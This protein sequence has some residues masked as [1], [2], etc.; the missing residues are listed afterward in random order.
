MY[1]LQR[2]RNFQ[3]IFRVWNF[4]HRQKAITYFLYTHTH[5]LHIYILTVDSRRTLS[6]L[7][8]SRLI[9]AHRNPLVKYLKS[10]QLA[11]ARARDLRSSIDRRNIYARDA[12]GSGPHTAPSCAINIREG[13]PRPPPLA[14]PGCRTHR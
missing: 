2:E 4:L 8:F 5:Q 6:I 13:G 3:T 14:L 1:N 11:S 9:R 10:C 12:R 7:Y